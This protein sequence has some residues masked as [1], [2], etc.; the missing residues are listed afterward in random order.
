MF[1]ERYQQFAFYNAQHCGFA[2]VHTA[3]CGASCAGIPVLFISADVGCS[4]GSEVAAALGRMCVSPLG[5]VCFYIEKSMFSPG[6]S[7]LL[8]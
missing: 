7:L 5:R 8:Q 3:V 4:A 2:G 6:D 1:L